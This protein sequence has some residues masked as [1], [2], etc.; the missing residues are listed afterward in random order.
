MIES[1]STPER[2]L[3]FLVSKAT[4][5]IWLLLLWLVVAAAIGVTLVSSS[6]A[7]P[8]WVVSAT[9]MLG[10]GLVALTAYTYALPPKVA[11]GRVGI[12][13]AIATEGR[14][15]DSKVQFD[16]VR[17]VQRVLDERPTGIPFQVNVVPSR[18]FP[19]GLDKREAEA[20]LRET[21]SRFLLYGDLRKRKSAARDVYSLRFS[22]MVSHEP[23][24][25]QNSQMLSE[26]M[27]SVLPLKLDIDCNVD[28][29]GFEMT[30]EQIANGAKY[31]VAIAYFLSNAPREAVQLLQSLQQAAPTIAR[32]PLP[33]SKQL[34]GLVER[35]LCDFQ[36]HRASLLH[37]EWRHSHRRQLLEEAEQIVLSL[38][39]QLRQRHEVRNILAIC[40]F[41]LRDD[42]QL[43]QATFNELSRAEPKN[44]MWMYSLAFLAAFNGDLEAAHRLYKKAFEHDT[45]DALSIEIEEFVAWCAER[46]PDRPQLFYCLGY[47]NGRQKKDADR[48]ISDLGRFLELADKDQYA[49]R[50]DLARR[51][52]ER[53]RRG[54]WIN[55]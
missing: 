32:N 2:L 51:Y 15:E 53:L 52:I 25:E 20:L 1:G 35:R 33:L 9:A 8:L 37:F 55:S 47:I 23:T 48:A 3:G 4:K 42:F 5:P 19:S 29:E 26:E 24:T 34:S 31:I 36:L 18:I 49:R 41:V 11:K 6:L 22:G 10:S 50:I 40:G 39:Q 43:A 28:L 12:S 16:L 38:P 14:P 45:S 44:P 30:S 17:T 54:E 46:H 27:T 7:L 21:R 13:F